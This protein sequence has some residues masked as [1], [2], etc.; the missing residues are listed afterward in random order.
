[1]EPNNVRTIR[2]FYRLFYN[3]KRLEEGA[4]LISGNFANHHPGARGVGPE[5]V[6]DDYR[7]L[8]IARVPDRHVEPLRIF[9][10][11]DLMCVISRVTGVGEGKQAFCVDLWRLEKG[12]LAEHW[13]VSRILGEDED[14]SAF[15]AK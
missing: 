1:M 9:E 11:G 6:V 8:A 5:G 4:K 14:A 10:Q 15:F 13:D 7:R 12:A 3:E 2:E